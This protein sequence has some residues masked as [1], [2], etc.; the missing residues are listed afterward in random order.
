MKLR[1][2][3]NTMRLRLNQHEVARLATGATLREELRFP[4]AT[5]LAYSLEASAGTKPGATYTDNQIRII[6]P[7]T[8]VKAWAE[9][10][11]IGLYF[12]FAAERS[13]LKVAIEKDLECLDG[14]EQERDPHAFPRE[15]KTPC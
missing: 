10:D 5:V 2:R 9:G 13:A 3:Q 12:E 6:A 8:D 7:Q 11:E 4:A 15:E 14:P 1:F